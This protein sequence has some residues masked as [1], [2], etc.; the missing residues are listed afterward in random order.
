MRIVRA[1][2]F[3]AL[4]A[5]LSCDTFNGGNNCPE[6]QGQYFDVQGIEISNRQSS[7][8]YDE[9][10]AAYSIVP[11]HQFRM[12]LDFDANYYASAARPSLLW[13]SAFAFNCKQ[14]GEKGSKESISEFE[15][16]TLFDID[17]NHP[18]GSKVNDM[19]EYEE[20]GARVPLNTYLKGNTRKIR[21][22]SNYLYLTC[23]PLHND[24][25][26]FKITLILDNG[27][28]YTEITSPVI[29]E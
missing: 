12:R 28:R 18:K 21:D 3:F 25:A 27:E 15:I 26:A 23:E 24:T 22:E 9:K 4:L 13:N 11:F 14:N 16:I 2:G 17:K 6:I 1:T 20:W 19:F 10:V 5:L 8:C 29:F 7:A